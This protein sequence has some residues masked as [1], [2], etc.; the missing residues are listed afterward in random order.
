MAA[1][2]GNYPPVTTNKKQQFSQYLLAFKP[3]KNYFITPL[4]IDLNIAVYLFLLFVGADPIS[5]SSDIILKWGAN[6]A[7]LTFDGQWWR[8]FTCC[9]LHFGILHI[10]FNMYALFYIGFLLEPL[11][12]KSRFLVAYL[13]CGLLSSLASLWWNTLIVSAGA[14]GAIFGMYGLFLA[15]LTTNLIPKQYRQSQLNIMVVFVVFNLAFGATGGIDNAAHIGGLLAGI[16]IGYL[17]YPSI[18]RPRLTQFKYVTVVLLIVCVGGSSVFAYQKIPHDGATYYNIVT[19]FDDLDNK[20]SHYLTQLSTMP[21]EETQL[22]G[23]N[24]LNRDY[25]QRGISLLSQTES[26]NVS[27]KQHQTAKQLIH[28]CNLRIQS[29]RLNYKAIKE[30]TQKYDTQIEDIDTQIQTFINNFSSDS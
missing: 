1:P 16:V 13:S 10:A 27:E 8:L 26:L 2:Y 22:Q 9:F 18:I 11:L 14:S 20:A 30:R 25:W 5:P 4:I 6:F 7:P 19:K 29:N 21:R 3:R 12:G 17:Y 15:L 24:H 23:L 28:Y